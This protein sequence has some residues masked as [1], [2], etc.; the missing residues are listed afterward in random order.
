M[1]I[2]C[3]YGLKCKYF[4]YVV[5]H[6]HSRCC[7]YATCKRVAVMNHNLF[8]LLHPGVVSQVQQELTNSQP[9]C[10]L[11]TGD[12]AMTV[13]QTVTLLCKSC[14][15]CCCLILIL[16][17][18]VYQEVFTLAS[19]IFFFRITNFSEFVSPVGKP[20]MWVQRISGLDFLPEELH[21]RNVGL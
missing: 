19:S 11:A 3:F 20:Y 2:S 15:F 5:R 14:A 4:L 6:F 18:V 17:K 9:I 8:F 21:V 16:V 10:K 13:L 12:K 7:C 1:L